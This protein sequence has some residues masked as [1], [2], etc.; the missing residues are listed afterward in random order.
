MSVQHRGVALQQAD[1]ASA[2]D[3]AAVAAADAALAVL[4]AAAAPRELQ[5]GAAVTL[6][7]AAAYPTVPPRA[8][9][10]SIARGL[11]PEVVLVTSNV[12]TPSI[13]LLFLY[14]CLCVCATLC[15]VMGTA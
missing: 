7:A 8:L 2:G 15:I 11:F 1:P 4:S 5:G 12:R 9:G 14:L 13:Q 3:S 6:A 10:Q